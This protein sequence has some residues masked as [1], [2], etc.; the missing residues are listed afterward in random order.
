MKR[1]TRPKGHHIKT[2]DIM[3]RQQRKDFILENIRRAHSGLRPPDANRI[4]RIFTNDGCHEQFKCSACPANTGTTEKSSP[5]MRNSPTSFEVMHH[6]RP[7]RCISI[8]VGVHDSRWSLL[9][10]IAQQQKHSRAY[11]RHWSMV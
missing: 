10:Q 11:F 6:D 2:W 7:Q 3:N 5:T 1:V 8:I 4:L 9:Q